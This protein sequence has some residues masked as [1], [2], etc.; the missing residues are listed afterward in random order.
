MENVLV[1]AYNRANSSNQAME[2]ADE[3]LEY[4]GLYNKRN[5]LLRTDIGPN[6]KT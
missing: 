1:G 6:Q 2:I 3:A 5:V 4:L